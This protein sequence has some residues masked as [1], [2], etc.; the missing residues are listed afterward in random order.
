M[1]GTWRLS[2]RLSDEERVRLQTKCA[3][4]GCDASSLVRQILNHHLSPAEA[5]WPQQRLERR[6]GTRAP[7]LVDLAAEYR[8]FGPG[9]ASEC[10]ALFQRLLIAAHCQMERTRNRQDQDLAISLV[11]LGQRHGLLKPL[12]DAPS[13]VRP[14]LTA[15]SSR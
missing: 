14:T 1:N 8:A 2:V 7:T 12:L 5:A 4:S 13:N 9:L 15:S 3:E 6:D 11:S 10:Q